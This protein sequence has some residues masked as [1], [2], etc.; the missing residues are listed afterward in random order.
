MILTSLGPAP[1]RCKVCLQSARHSLQGQHFSKPAWK[2]YNT[3]NFAHCVVFYNTMLHKATLAQ[4]QCQ[5]TWFSQ[6]FCTSA[7]HMVAE[8]ALTM[9]ETAEREIHENNHRLSLIREIR[10]STLVITQN[11]HATS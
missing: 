2:S 1:R 10:P 11:L 6:Q 8:L 5:V 3:Y 9:R 4:V 7:F